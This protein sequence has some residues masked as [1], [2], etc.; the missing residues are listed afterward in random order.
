[1]LAQVQAASIDNRIHPNHQPI[2][3]PTAIN[4]TIRLLDEPESTETDLTLAE[5]QTHQTV[6]H[7]L[8]T[9]DSAPMKATARVLHYPWTH[10]PTS[11]PK[12]R[13]HVDGGANR[14]ITNNKDNLLSYRNIKRYP[15]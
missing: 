9:S 7:A 6:T 14:S 1:M 5:T 8:A 15:M 10:P 11:I 13:V 12:V 2:L 3:L 4:P